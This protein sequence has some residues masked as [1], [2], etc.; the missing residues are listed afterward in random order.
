MMGGFKE[1]PL[2]YYVSTFVDSNEN[3]KNGSVKVPDPV[4]A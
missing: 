3:K 4:T 1:S 2:A